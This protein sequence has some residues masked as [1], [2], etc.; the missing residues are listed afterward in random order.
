MKLTLTTY[1]RKLTI[2]TENEDI[3]IDE[4][5][6]MFEGLLYQAGFCTTTICFGFRDKA[7]EMLG[8]FEN[9]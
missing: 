3:D 1:G 4:Y 9:D 2:E 7:D 8:C 6:R 5:M